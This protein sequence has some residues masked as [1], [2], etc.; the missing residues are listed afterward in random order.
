M[1]E[2]NDV[3]VTPKQTSLKQSQTMGLSVANLIKS[4]KI[5]MH[6]LKLANKVD[7]PNHVDFHSYMFS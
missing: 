1:C 7:T 3:I 5:T 2:S 4:M 6:S